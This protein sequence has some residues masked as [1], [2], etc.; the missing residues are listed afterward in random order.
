M[1][2]KTRATVDFFSVLKRL[3][4]LLPRMNDEDK[5]RVFVF[6]NRAEQSS[7]R[8][9]ALIQAAEQLLSKYD[10]LFALK[11][12]G[13]AIESRLTAIENTKKLRE[14]LKQFEA[15]ERRLVGCVSREEAKQ[16]F[17]DLDRVQFARVKGPKDKRSVPV[18][19][20]WTF[21]R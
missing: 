17:F 6:V 14:G 9:L 16:F 13:E 5:D 15:A 20:W 12:R 21:Q 1:G 10:P 8:P 11:K 4:A 7:Y 3:V 18:N 2:L 19:Q